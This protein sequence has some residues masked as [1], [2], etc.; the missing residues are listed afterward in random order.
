[1]NLRIST[2]AFS[3]ITLCLLVYA[4]RSNTTV[5]Q[6]EVDISAISDIEDKLDALGLEVRTISNDHQGT[7]INET[8]EIFISQPIDHEDNSK[9]YFKQ[10]IYLSHSTYDAPMVMYLSGYNSDDNRY[11]TEPAYILKANQINVEHRFFGESGPEEIPYEYLTIEQSAADHHHIVE[12]LKKVYKEDWLNTGISKGGQTTMYHRYFYPEDVEA[13]VVYVAPLNQAREDDRIYDFLENVGSEECRNKVLAYQL[14]LLMNYDFA[15]GLFNDLTEEKGYEYGLSIEK[16]FEL[17]IFEYGFAFWQ[18][19]GDC[20]GIPAPESSFQEKMEHLFNV[21]AP[22]FFTKSTMTD[23]FPFFYQS[24]TEMGMYGYDVTPFRGLT[25]EYSSD[26]S[27]YSTFIPASFELTYDGTV[28]RQVQQ[29]LD[30]QADDMV[31]IYG[32]NDPWTATGY[33][34]SGKNNLYRYVIENGNHTSRI[35]H[36]K[37]GELEQIKD[38]INVWMSN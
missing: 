29:W 22:G 5:I 21:D 30:E 12:V 11:L 8:F 23:I 34:P 36:L 28:H 37:P 24:Y 2:L 17:S 13:S 9:G 4:C 35:A 14:E 18:W 15:L 19:S 7:H 1:M 10:K 32:E 25:R 20:D 31:F 27:N 3:A 38:S 16:A 6:Q 26:V 33:V